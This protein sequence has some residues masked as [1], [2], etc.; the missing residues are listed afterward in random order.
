MLK[1]LRFAIDLKGHTSIGG[2]NNSARFVSVKTDAPFQDFTAHTDRTNRVP[3]AGGHGSAVQVHVPGEPSVRANWD[4]CSSPPQPPPPSSSV[5]LSVPPAAESREKLP[6]APPPA[7]CR[8]RDA[9][10]V[11]RAQR[12]SRCGGDAVAALG[13]TGPHVLGEWFPKV[14]LEGA[15]WQV[16]QAE[17]QE[18]SPGAA[19]G[20]HGSEAAATSTPGRVSWLHHPTGTGPRS[21]HRLLCDPVS[22]STPVASHSHTARGRDRA[23]A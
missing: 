22:C 21:R 23:G 15:I 19:S 14:A 12:P 5:H 16:T 9:A 13:C 8:V 20:R 18:S 11:T 4:G 7:R 17:A 3:G 10:A 6:E 2:K 1:T